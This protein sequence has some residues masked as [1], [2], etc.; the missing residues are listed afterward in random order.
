MENKF[1]SRAPLTN[2][3]NG[4][5]SFFYSF[6]ANVGHKKALQIRD[7]THPWLHSITSTPFLV[8]IIFK[9]FHWHNISVI[10][11]Y[12]IAKTWF[13]LRSYNI[14]EWMSNM[15]YCFVKYM[16]NSTLYVYH[17]DIRSSLGADS[18]RGN[19]N[20]SLQL[21]TIRNNGIV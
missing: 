6:I 8:L 10:F 13:N 21:D 4:F 19:P 17:I 16:K 18:P 9:S 5:K 15:I 14:N 2:K 7:V 20:S 12:S 1:T 11:D 3:R